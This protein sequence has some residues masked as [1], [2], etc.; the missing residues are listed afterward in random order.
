MVLLTCSVTELHKTLSLS[1]SFILVCR[2]REKNAV[3]TIGRYVRLVIIVDDSQKR[4]HKLGFSDCRTLCFV[5]FPRPLCGLLVAT[6]SRYQHAPVRVFIQAT[7]NLQVRHREAL[8]CFSVVDQCSVIRYYCYFTY[9]CML[10]P[11]KSSV[12]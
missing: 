12:S 8:N 11:H 2:W 9:I 10:L 1:A 6:T 5:L 7:N 4:H 3:A